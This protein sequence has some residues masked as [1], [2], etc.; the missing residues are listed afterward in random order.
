VDNPPGSGTTYTSGTAIQLHDATYIW[1][2]KTDYTLRDAA[3]GFHKTVFGGAN[4]DQNT[5]Y[6]FKVTNTSG[7]SF[8]NN[9]LIFGL[10]DKFFTGYAYQSNNPYR[11]ELTAPQNKLRITFYNESNQASQV[12]GVENSGLVPAGTTAYIRLRRTSNDEFQFEYQNGAITTTHTL[13]LSFWSSNYPWSS[14]NYIY[15]ERMTHAISANW[16]PIVEIKRV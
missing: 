12:E 4:F 9:P 13:P 16:D 8:K 3:N 15:T 7:A 10:H 14:L 6:E 2:P 1:D 5:Y 11:L